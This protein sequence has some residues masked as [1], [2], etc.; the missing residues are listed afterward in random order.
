MTP[1][2]RP[3]T[4]R[5]ALWAG[6]GLAAAGCESLRTMTPPAADAA[7]PAGLS[8]KKPGKHWLRASQYV[9]YSDVPLEP[10]DSLFRELDGL[11]EQVQQEM[12]LPPGA[13]VVEVFLFE[14]QEKYE[15]FMKER[16]P[17]LPARR[18]YFI[19]EQKRPGADDLQV[20]TWM[21]EYIRTDLRHELTHATLHGVL[22][23][24]PLWLDEGLAGYFEQPPGMDGVNPNH[25]KALK[26]GAWRPDLAR[27][28][29]FGQVKQ[30]EQAEYREAWAWAHFLLR[31]PRAKPVLLEYAA[32]LRA[33]PD[34]G[35]L[36]PALQAAVG[37]PNRALAEH[38]ART[39]VPPPA[40]KA[41]ASAR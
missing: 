36:L 15:A 21:G 18:A 17:W 10:G 29:K 12:N 34:P 30:M 20:F 9:F 25:L 11:P 13:S 6:L 39:T 22:K 3:P 38:L 2:H 27:L 26:D 28:E 14:D 23:G 7:K 5:A 24:V 4:R 41:R 1:H 32:K 37:D 35:P 33:E 40:A 16:Y 31:D 19:A 8:A